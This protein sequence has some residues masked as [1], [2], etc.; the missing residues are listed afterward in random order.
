MR[1]ILQF[2]CLNNMNWFKFY[3][4]E[5]LTDPKMMSLSPVEKALWLTM[6][7]LA[8]NNEGEINHIDEQKI[9]LMTGISPLDD[10]WTE[11]EGFLKHF[12]TLSMITI[13]NKTVCIT[14]YSKRQNSNLSAYER[15]KRSREKKKELEAKKGDTNDNVINDNDRIDK[16][17]EDKNRKEEN[18]KATLS[19]AKKE[20]KFVLTTVNGLLNLFKDVNPNYQRLFSNKSQREAIERMI[21]IHGFVKLE[22]TVLAL[23]ELINRPY[24]PVI[25]TPLQLEQKM[26]DLIA[27]A[28]KEKKQNIPKIAI[29]Q[30]EE[31]N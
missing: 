26:G 16:I 11:N 24:A 21:K 20:D 17:R 22:K 29:M 15:V 25:T 23:K 4:Q 13:D 9:M 27:F 7:C 30:K 19:V 5:Y 2:P 8:S 10:E 6:L 14:N 31:F 12:E 3:G 28:N 1:E 18:I